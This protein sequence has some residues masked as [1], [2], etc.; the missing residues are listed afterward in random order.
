MREVILAAE[1]IRQTVCTDI[2]EELAIQGSEEQLLEYA[3]TNGGKT[4]REMLQT[5]RKD[6]V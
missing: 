4:I 5:V 3:A 6:H 1:S 2:P